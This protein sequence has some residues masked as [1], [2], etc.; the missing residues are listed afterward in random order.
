VGDD[1]L[2]ALYDRAMDEMRRVLT[3]DGTLVILTGVPALLLQSPRESL[4]ISLFGQNPTIS[5]F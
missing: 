2:R 4:E 3:P 5:I 1:D